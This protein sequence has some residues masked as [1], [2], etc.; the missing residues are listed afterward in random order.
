MAATARE[1]SSL[2]PEELFEIVKNTNGT[3][4]TTLWKIVFGSQGTDW[5]ICLAIVEEMKRQGFVFIDGQF[6]TPARAAEIEAEKLRL[7]EENY[8]YTT[9]YP[10]PVET[11][12]GRDLFNQV[13]TQISAVLM[14]FPDWSEVAQYS[15]YSSTQPLQP[16]YLALTTLRHKPGTDQHYNSTIHFHCKTGTEKSLFDSRNL[17]L[18]ILHVQ[19]DGHIGVHVPLSKEDTH[20]FLITVMQALAF[21]TLVGRIA[22]QTENYPTSQEVLTFFNQV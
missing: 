12:A 19:L 6:E 4:E 9:H 14:T 3:D 10:V 5:T 17:T 11:E 16:N 18:D 1:L 2:S 7:F 20:F 13:T 21:L 22:H 8:R 15:G